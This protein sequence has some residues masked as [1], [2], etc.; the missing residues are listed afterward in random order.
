MGPELMEQFRKQAERF[1]T[2]IVS[3]DVT[4]W[5]SAA[6]LSRSGLVRT[7]TGGLDHHLHRRLGPLARRAGRGGTRGYGVSACATCDGFFFR[8][9][10][11][12]VVGGGDSAMEE[13]LFPH[14]VRHEGD[15]HPPPRRVPRFGDH[16]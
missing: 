6:D 10:N 2:R 16:G 12:A 15:H 14:Q 4:G 9:R 8:D 1:G 5:T 7:C 3:S 13:A 11:L